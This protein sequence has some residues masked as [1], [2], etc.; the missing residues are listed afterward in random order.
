[1]LSSNLTEQEKALLEQMMNTTNSA[2]NKAEHSIK[3]FK[4]TIDMYKSLE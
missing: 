2:I 1:M 4:I 3:S